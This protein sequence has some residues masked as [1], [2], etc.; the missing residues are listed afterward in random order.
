MR[1]LQTINFDHGNAH[2]KLFRITMDS[3]SLDIANDIEVINVDTRSA[4]ILCQMC[5][6]TTAERCKEYQIVHGCHS[7]GRLGQAVGM[8]DKI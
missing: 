1:L 2:L 6:G 8:T 5:F 3:S 4:Y 7:C